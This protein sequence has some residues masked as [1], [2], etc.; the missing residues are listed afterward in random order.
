MD[1]VDGKPVPTGQ[2]ETLEADSVSLALGQDTDTGFLG[3]VE[4]STFKADG[5]VIVGSDMMTGAQ[6]IFAG[7][8]MVPGERSVTIAVGHGKKAA[9][10]INGYLQSKPYL[11][12]PKHQLIGFEKLNTWFRTHAPKQM[13]QHLPLEDAV[14]DFSEIVSGLT[15]DEARY[16]AARCFSCGI[17]SN[18]MVVMAH[19]RKEP[20]SN[21]DQAND[22]SLTIRFVPDVCLNAQFPASDRFNPL[23]L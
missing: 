22:M 16:E 21:W 3:N 13:Q 9:R 12:A 23:F 8:D 4:G 14:K 2:V 15:P 17:A 1:I 18:A 7:G 20:L 19:A 6:G 5:T 10:Y 11:P